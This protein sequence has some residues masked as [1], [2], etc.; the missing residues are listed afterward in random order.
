[1]SGCPHRDGVAGVVGDI[2][3]VL[4]AVYPSDDSIHD[5]DDDASLLL[6]LLVL[7]SILLAAHHSNLDVDAAIDV[8]L[9]ANLDVDLLLRNR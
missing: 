5:G 8:H 6:V 1:M 9:A 3:D 4:L 2:F 7:L